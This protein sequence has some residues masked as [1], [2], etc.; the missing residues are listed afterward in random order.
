[1]A[2]IYVTMKDTDALYESVQRHVEEEL[3]KSDLPQDEKLLVEEARKEKYMEILGKFFEYGEYIT[4]KFNT[5]DKTARV[6]SA[7]ELEQGRNA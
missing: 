6:V 4:I 3:E 7:Y 1:M 5:E 2:D